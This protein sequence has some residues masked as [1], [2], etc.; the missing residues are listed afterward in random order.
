MRPVSSRGPTRSTAV[1]AGALRDAGRHDHDILR[2]GT[3]RSISP[4]AIND[5][6]WIT[7][8]SGDGP[9]FVRHPDGSFETFAVEGARYTTALA[10]NANGYIAG[11]YSNADLSSG[12][13]LR[14]ARRHAHCLVSASADKETSVYGLN[15][16]NIMVDRSDLGEDAQAFGLVMKPAT[17]LAGTSLGDQFNVAPVSQPHPTTIRGLSG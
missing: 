7:G 10:I 2:P 16:S 3:V 17:F 14:R 12:S 6:G 9:A 4:T 15:D 1:Q 5:A 13:F 11:T 8:Y